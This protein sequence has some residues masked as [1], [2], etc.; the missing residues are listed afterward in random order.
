MPLIFISLNMFVDEI[1]K[2]LKIVDDIL[3]FTLTFIGDNSLIACGV[4]SVILSSEENIKLKLKHKIID[5]VGKELNISE[6]GGGDVYVK[7]IIGGVN[8][9]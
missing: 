7:G 4:K 3:P 1:Q 9:E 5:I 2:K 8:F 6:I